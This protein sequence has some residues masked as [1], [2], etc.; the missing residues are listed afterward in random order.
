M[1]FWTG[2]FA[3]M[4]RATLEEGIDTMVKIVVGLLTSKR[5]RPS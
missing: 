2:L 5:S 1:K 3:E 4:D